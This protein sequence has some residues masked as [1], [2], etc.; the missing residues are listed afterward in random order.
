MY[1]RRYVEADYILEL[2]NEMGIAGTIEGAEAMSFARSAARSAATRRWSRPRRASQV[3]G[4]SRRFA[5]GLR[6]DRLDNADGN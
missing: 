1:R 6:D 4:L 5:A 2:V 3:G